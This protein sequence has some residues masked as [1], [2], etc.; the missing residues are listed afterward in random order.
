MCPPRPCKTVPDQNPIRQH[1]QGYPNIPACDLGATPALKPSGLVLYE[2]LVAEILRIHREQRC[3]R[4]V[5]NAES[6]QKQNLAPSS[7]VPGRVG[8]SG[9]LCQPVSSCAADGLWHSRAPKRLVFLLVRILRVLAVVR[10]ECK[11]FPA[12][13]PK[14]AGLCV[15]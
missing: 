5:A 8:A 2:R 3:S 7:V 14:F 10:I 1:H 4:S 11:H 6:R 13:T 12:L 9:R 15:E